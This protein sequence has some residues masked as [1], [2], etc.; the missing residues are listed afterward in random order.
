M[1]LI[2][3]WVVC[4]ISALLI[5]WLLG[6]STSETRVNLT[7]I[8][9]CFH[10]VVVAI[11]L[12]GILCDPELLFVASTIALTAFLLLEAIRLYDLEYIGAFLTQ[13]VAGFLDEKDQGTLILTHIYLLVGCSLP[14][15]IS[16]FRIASN[17]SQR[18]LLCAGV[19]SLGV[20]DTAASVGGTLW[21]KTKL[22]NSSKSVEGTICSILAEI[23]FIALLYS[24]GMALLFVFFYCFLSYRCFNFTIIDQDFLE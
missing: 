19:I 14:I 2:L 8:R 13:K 17:A 4:T 3:Y 23:C 21:G 24:F 12:P 20:G 11:Y 7:V 9:K 1:F 6:R 10:G 5:V 16:P 22:P 15:W 18:L